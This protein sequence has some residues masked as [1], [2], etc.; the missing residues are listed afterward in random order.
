MKKYN[1]EHL[2]DVATDGIA[3]LLGDKINN[4]S[5]EEFAVWEKYQLTVCERKD[6]QGYSGHMLYI[7]KKK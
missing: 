6:L 5:K 7:C 1:V 4:L 2:H 3:P